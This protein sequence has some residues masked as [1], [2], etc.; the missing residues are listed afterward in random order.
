M[1]AMFSTKQTQEMATML[2]QL[3]PK[4]YVEVCVAFQSAAVGAKKEVIFFKKLL[5]EFRTRFTNFPAGQLQINCRTA[6]VHQK[7]I[8]QTDQFG[9]ELA[10]LLV[11]VKFRTASGVIE[12]KS[13]L[14]QVKM[15]NAGTLRA[16]IDQRQLTLLTEWP[17][18]QFGR[19]ANGNP[20]L[21]SIQPRTI[22][23]G[24][25][26]IGQRGPKDKQWLSSPLFPWFCY[27]CYGVAPSAL[28]VKR[29]GPK[30]VNCDSIPEPCSDVCNMIRHLVFDLG[31]PHVFNPDVQRLVDALYRYVELS[32]D[33]PKEFD[34]YTKETGR[35]EIGFGV[36]EFS[37]TL[38]QKR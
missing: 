32:P 20:E 38:E 16:T 2:R 17:R 9:C 18:F 35:D 15:C 12:S 21:F 29:E 8:V 36:I 13:V 37:V 6:E 25:Y 10:D 34:E 33:P 11:V 30:S 4:I 7:P 31:E 28:T 26:L 27:P 22:E 14:Y 24:S 23:F 19:R 1:P 5:D 3:W